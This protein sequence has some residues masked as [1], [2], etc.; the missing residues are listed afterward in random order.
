MT[1]TE[2]FQ[3]FREQV[4]PV[5]QKLFQSIQRESTLN[6]AFTQK[7]QVWLNFRI[8]MQCLGGSVS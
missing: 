7:M 4:I 1:T 8:S 3:K 6:P 5:P 2:F